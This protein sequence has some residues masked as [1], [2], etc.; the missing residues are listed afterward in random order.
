MGKGGGGGRTDERN[1]THVSIHAH[2][3]LNPDKYRKSRRNF[4]MS[5]HIAL[6]GSP[7]ILFELQKQIVNRKINTNK[8]L[9]LNQFDSMPTSS[10]IMFNVHVNWN[11]LISVELCVCVC[12]NRFRIDIDL[13]YIYIEEQAGEEVGEHKV[14]ACS[15]FI[16]KNVSNNGIS[17]TINSTQF[18]FTQKCSFINALSLQR[19]S[20]SPMPIVCDR[21]WRAV[22]Y[23]CVVIK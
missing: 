13:A 11:I 2:I 3:A 12:V 14:S 1:C 23:A 4:S 9:L 20:E 10:Y 6:L 7:Y 16:G 5:W 18:L 8:H 15:R 19:E 21:L 17:L 22:L